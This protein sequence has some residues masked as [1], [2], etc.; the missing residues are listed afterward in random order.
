M[1]VRTPESIIIGAIHG[2][3]TS[4]PEGDGGPH[5]DYQW[6]SPSTVRTSPR[7]SLRNWLRTALRS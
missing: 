6:I 4:Y 7:L 5:L 1:A 3:L 2:A